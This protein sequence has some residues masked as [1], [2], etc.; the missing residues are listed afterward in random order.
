MFNL[1]FDCQQYLRDRSLDS[2]TLDLLEVLS[3]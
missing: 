1:Q 2:T 3:P